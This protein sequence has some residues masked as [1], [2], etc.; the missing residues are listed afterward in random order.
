MYDVLYGSGTETL[1]NSLVFDTE[2]ENIYLR[3][4]FALD[5]A[6]ED[7][8]VEANNAY[9]YDPE[10]GMALIRQK[11]SIDITNLV[12]DGYPFYCGELTAE[13]LL[14]YR[15]GDATVL[16]LT[17]RYSTVCV[18]VN[19]RKVRKGLF[20]E[21]VDIAEY[22]QEGENTVT[23]SLCNNY[24]NLLGPHH[25]TEVESMSVSPLTFSM[26]KRWEGG[27]CPLYDGRY[28]FVRFGIDIQSNV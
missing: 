15:S 5:M 12:T 27:R 13:A 25:S 18:E 3:G 22:L 1:R 26:E 24:R 8:S 10:R 2:I 21:Y 19:G 9:R 23:V 16:R 17:G 7:F 11:S 4:S 6:K 20:D 14:D 28:S